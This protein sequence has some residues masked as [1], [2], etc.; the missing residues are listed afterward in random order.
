MGVAD[1]LH[2]YLPD[3]LKRF[4]HNIPR[5][6]LKAIKAIMQCRTPELGGEVYY[7]KSCHKYHYSYHSCKNRHCPKCGG[8]NAKKWLEKQ[9]KKLLPVDYFMVTFTLPQELRFICRSNQRLL[10]SIM[11]KASSNALKTLLGDPKYAGGKAGFIGIL[12]TWTRILM[13]HPH[14]HYIVPAGAF[15]VVR[16]V[17]NPSSHQFLIPIKALSKLFRKN[18][19][20]LLK[21]ENLSIFQSI[22]NHIW[23]TKGFN[24]NSEKKGRGKQ[25]LQY[26]SQYVYRTAISDK[27]IIGEQ[28]GKVTFKYKPSGKDHYRT[29][30]VTAIEFIRRFLQHVLPT[31]FQKVRY[32]GF[33]NAAA[34]SDWEKIRTFFQMK[35][36]INSPETETTPQQIHYCPVCKSKMIYIDSFYRKSRAPPEVYFEKYSHLIS[37]R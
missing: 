11:F 36:E 30:T 4:G 23:Y 15:D 12:H 29:Q 26:L 34:K 1:I 20:N 35:E 21:K 5:F 27:N 24:T 37:P 2:K 33:L 18:F 14:I 17:W 10:Y 32:Y 6:H 13:Y 31:G 19:Q 22:P 9:I 16:N 25:V 28:N 7:C 3:Y 8:N